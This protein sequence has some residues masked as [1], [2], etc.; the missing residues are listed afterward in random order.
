MLMS[1]SDYGMYYVKNRCKENEGNENHSDLLNE[2][3]IENK[4][5]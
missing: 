1:K 2:I 4:I 3:S 5:N